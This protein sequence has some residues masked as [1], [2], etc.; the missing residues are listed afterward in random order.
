MFCLSRQ[1][2]RWMDIVL[3]TITI[4]QY[5]TNTQFA[6]IQQHWEWPSNKASSILP[7]PKDKTTPI[8]C[9]FHQWESTLL[10][11]TV[12]D[13]GTGEQSL[14][15]MLPH[16]RMLWPQSRTQPCPCIRNKHECVPLLFWKKGG[17]M[18]IALMG[19]NIHCTKYVL[20]WTPHI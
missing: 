1:L 17:K 11:G 18:R 5:G 9:P 4:K 3:F 6:L 10:H 12:L 19:T 14:V 8:G 16:A 13:P 15:A 7:S 20:L 2:S